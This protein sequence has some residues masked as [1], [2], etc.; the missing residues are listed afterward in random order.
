MKELNYFARITKEEQISN[1]EHDI[2]PNTF[3]LEMSKPFPA[4]YGGNFL[5][6]NSEPGSIL[7]VLKEEMDFEDFFRAVKRIQEYCSHE[8][9]AALAKVYV[10]NLELSAIRIRDVK[11]FSHI[12]EIQ[13][14][15]MNEKIEMAKPRNINT[16]A[17]IKI[18]KF[19]S[20]GEDGDGIFLDGVK[21]HFSY[22][23]VPYK[24]SWKQFEKITDNVRHNTDAKA[25]DV[26]KGVFYTKDGMIDFIRVFTEK[27]TPEELKNIQSK[28]LKYYNRL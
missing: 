6:S 2:I 27:I 21:S 8:F 19:I 1:L 25:Y 15:F 22:F 12:K 7:L 4:Y 18:S 24:V 16:K 9:D 20:I 3:V 26:A 13:S 14:A 5:T 28:F 11:A 23:Q 10:Y 17:L